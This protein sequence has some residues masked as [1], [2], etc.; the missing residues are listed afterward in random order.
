[1]FDIFV[2]GLVELVKLKFSLL[3]KDKPAMDE[4]ENTAEESDQSTPNKPEEEN[5]A[6]LLAELN[7][8]N[9]LANNLVV[10]KMPRLA[11]MNLRD[12]FLK[13]CDKLKLKIST[14]DIQEIQ[15][16]PRDGRDIRDCRE[17]RDDTIVCLKSYE[18]K[19]EIRIAAQRQRIFSGDVFDL[20]PDQWSKPIKMISH[21]TR[22]YSDMLN[23]A[24]DA[25]NDRAIF[26]Y[27]LSNRGV[28]IKRLRTSDD[29]IFISKTELR[30]FLK[31][32]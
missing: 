17:G 6:F 30:N 7:K 25:R 24:K 16:R 8:Q 18:L 13:L 11:N 21:T 3:I 26:H 9:A 4:T 19:E 20:L 22:Y 23:I 14:D 10:V 28:H 27:E 2:E 31:R 32:S 29:R 5:A 15:R 1:M 12:M